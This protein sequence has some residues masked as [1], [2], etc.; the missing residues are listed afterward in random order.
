MANYYK[1]CNQYSTT[2]GYGTTFNELFTLESDNEEIKAYC[3]L[4]YGYH[5]PL[6]SFEVITYDYDLIHLTGNA[7]VKI[8]TEK[9][10]LEYKLA[11]LK[12]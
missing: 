7:K 10:E 5:E 6:S 4:K 3:A 8:Y 9:L 11:E 2:D 12:L 1:K